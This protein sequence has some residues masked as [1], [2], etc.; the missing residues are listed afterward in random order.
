MAQNDEAFQRTLHEIVAKAI[1][2]VLGD[3]IS[4]ALSFYVDLRSALRNPD[5][6]LNVIHELV[7]PRSA[8]Q[9]RQN[10]LRNLYERF[11]LQYE[12]A[13]GTF[14]QEIARLRN[15]NR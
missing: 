15:K 8:E 7:G 6:F 2:E 9:L 13:V 5:R 3:R 12:R 11:G 4:Q 14:A 1:V 10:I